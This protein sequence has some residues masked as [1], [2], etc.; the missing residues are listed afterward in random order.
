MAAWLVCLRLPVSLVGP[1]WIPRERDLDCRLVRRH[2]PA[3]DV[4]WPVVHLD[5]VPVVSRLVRLG[6]AFL[7]GSPTTI[8]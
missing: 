1:A 6:D 4:W 2:L 3:V 5:T 7:G 8:A